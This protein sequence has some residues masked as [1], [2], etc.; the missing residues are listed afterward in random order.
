M[1]VENDWIQYFPFSNPRKEQVIAINFILNAFQEGKKYVIAEL[2]TGIGKS[3]LGLTISKFIQANRSKFKCSTINGSWFL[4]TQKTL[5]AQYVADFG[6]KHK[7]KTIKSSNNYTCQMFDTS[8]IHMTCAEIQRLMKAHK[9]FQTIYKPCMSKCRYR[10]EKEKFIESNDSLTNYSYFFAESTYAKEIQPRD[11]LVLDECH[12]LE[13]GLSK[14]IEIV[15]SENFSKNK[16]NLKKFPKKH[17][18]VSEIIKWVSTKY[19]KALQERIDEVKNYLQDHQ[20]K[21]EKVKSL[22]SYV[23][24]YEILDKHICKLNRFIEQY[25]ESNWVHTYE[26]SQSG[27]NKI[28]FKPIDVSIFSKE[29]LFDFG[30]HVLLMSA[31]I[32][33]KKTFCKSLGIP[34]EQ[35][36]FIRLP[37]PF[38]SENRPLHILPVGHMS[39]NKIDATLPM[40]ASIVENILEMHENDKGVIHCVSFK[41]SN[42]LQQNIKSKRILIHDSS[43]REEIINYHCSTDEPTVL[44]SPSMLEG[45][46]LKD[47]RSRFQIL[48]KLPFPFLGDEVVKKRMSLNPDWYACET[49]KSIIQGLGRSI[50][51]ENDHAESYILDSDWEAFFKRN[52]RM[53]PKEIIDSIVTT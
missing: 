52:K 27:F 22:T 8:N 39:K 14:F 15:L 3:A 7:L 32:L 36:S 16:L 37:S 43:N 47:D 25:N 12:T 28:V 5:Q 9:F 2:S 18:N 10:D 30:N 11:L 45:V 35:S 20:T 4:T 44:V 38:K 31:T 13:D 53:F 40:M 24:E 42:Y 1:I 34:D 50:R 46:D 19:K 33:D 6:V 26:E 21:E 41:I 17:D 29:K 49:I 51:N 48:C 23:K